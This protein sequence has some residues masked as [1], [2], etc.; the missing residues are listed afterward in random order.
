MNVPVLRPELRRKEVIRSMEDRSEERHASWL[1]LFYDLA[2]VAAIGQLGTTLAGNFT[3]QSFGIAAALFVAIWWGWVGQTFYLS[4]F[5]S[6][7]LQH[8]ILTMVQIFIVVAMAVYIPQA[9]EGNLAGFVVSFVLMRATLVW[10]YLSTGRHLPEAKRLTET[11]SMGFGLAALI[12]LT[13]T[14][15]PIQF[16][17]V[18]WF[19]AIAVDFAT[20]FICRQLA[21]DIPP[22][23]GHFPERFGLFTII[24]LGEGILSAVN[25]LRRDQLGPEA[26]IGG[27]LALA[28]FC[29]MWWIYFEGVRGATVAVPTTTQ[30]I[31][32]TI[33][34]LY[35][36]LLL[37][38]SI[39]ICAVGFKKMLALQ[40]GKALPEHVRII[41]C[42]SVFLLMASYQVIWYTGLN[43]Q[44]HP[45]AHRIGL[46]HLLVTG[47]ML[48]VTAISG[49]MSAL[50]LS[51]VVCL[52]GFGHLML[53]IF[54]RPSVRLLMEANARAEKGLPH[55]FGLFG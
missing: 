53:V 49:F 19:V 13:S 1:E 42:L 37:T 31:T 9:M 39:V 33:T 48:L 35:T 38:F 54:D 25:G 30:E 45:F 34:W 7:D 50:V 41:F 8:R 5:D 43:K 47:T 12:W 21:L 36:H 52:L 24:V 17:F 6:D 26:L 28:F 23:Y 11:Y 32:R 20:P 44:L 15:V 55:E 40:A 4:R 29:T 18:L 3:M 16:A 10:Q 14:F 51:G 27:L 22:D 2:F 46:P